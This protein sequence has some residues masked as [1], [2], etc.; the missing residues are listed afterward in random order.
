[1]LVLPMGGINDVRCWD[2]LRWYDI[3][4]VKWRLVQAFKQY[5]GFDSEIRE[6]VM[7]VLLMGEIYKVRH[8]N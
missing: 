6:A 8:W 4:Q 5:Y 7:L 1:M 3:Y 2:G